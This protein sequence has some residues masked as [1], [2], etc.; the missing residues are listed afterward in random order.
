[1]D[2]FAIC[3]CDPYQAFSGRSRADHIPFD[4]ASARI[5]EKAAQELD[6][7]GMGLSIIR[8]SVS[9]VLY[10]RKDGRNRLF[11]SFRLEA[12]S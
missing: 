11:L 3:N 6:L 5:K 8:K 12:G 2:L 9:S 1:M 10:G 7:G 4:P